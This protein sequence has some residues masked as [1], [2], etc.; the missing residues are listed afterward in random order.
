MFMLKYRLCHVKN[1]NDRY[2]F[3]R[4]ATVIFDWW[5][6]RITPMRMHV[7]KKNRIKIFF[8]IKNY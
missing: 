1:S 6:T 3:T 5:K 2:N 4:N 7:E 8:E